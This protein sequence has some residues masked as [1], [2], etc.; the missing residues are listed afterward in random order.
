MKRIVWLVAAALCLAAVSVSASTYTAEG[1]FSFDYPDHWIVDNRTYT[2]DN[3]EDYTWIADVYDD[4]Y[5]MTVSIEMVDGFEGFSLFRASEQEA[6]H[7][8]QDIL[9]SYEAYHPEYLD[10]WTS[11][12]VPF[13]VISLVEDDA[14]FVE[15]LTIANGC[16]I[17]F[18]ISDADDDR[19]SATQALK[20]IVDSF[21]PAV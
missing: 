12:G 1:L 21:Q 8:T 11:A 15:A 4:D 18:S 2:G 14:L 6:E 20:E 7:Y 10:T 19:Q 3:T 9:D 17:R 16:E 13:V 5:Y